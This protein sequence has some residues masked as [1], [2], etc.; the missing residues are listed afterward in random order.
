MVD[1]AG[2]N[3]SGGTMWQILQ[4]LMGAVCKLFGKT[5]VI[6]DATNTTTVDVY[7]KTSVT[8]HSPA[9]AMTNGGTLS[10]VLTQAGPSPV[11]SADG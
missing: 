1:G 4:G 6:G 11:L 3:G 8:V 2:N 9:I 5:M 10:P 7:G